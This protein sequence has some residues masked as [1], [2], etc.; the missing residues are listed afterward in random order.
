MRD[1]VIII[2]MCN[3]LLQFSFCFF[4]KDTKKKKRYIRRSNMEKYDKTEDFF[5]CC[6][7]VL[8]FYRFIA[9]DANK[10]FRC[11]NSEITHIVR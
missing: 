1:S 5:C 10:Y 8:L 4:S 6:L 9:I 2:Y 7:F 3:Y 11:M